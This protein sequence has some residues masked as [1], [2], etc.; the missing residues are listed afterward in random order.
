MAIYSRLGAR[1]RVVRVATLRDIR[2]IERRRPT[3]WDRNCVGRADYLVV[4]LASRKL[5]LYHRRFLIADDGP[6][7]VD[8]AIPSSPG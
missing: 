8:A 6:G 3:D 2:A 1:V 7:E 5:E 4:R